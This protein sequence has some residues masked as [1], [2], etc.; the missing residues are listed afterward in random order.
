MRMLTSLSVDEILLPRYVKWNTNFRNWLSNVENTPSCLKY[1]NIFYLCSRQSW[2]ADCSGF[3]AE[4]RFEELYLRKI[5]F[6]IKDFRTI[7]F[8]F[9]VISKTFRPICS[10]AFFRCLSKSGTYTE[11]RTTSF[12]E[13][14]RV[15][16][17]DSVS[18]NRVQ[19]LSILVLLLT[20]SQ[21]WTCNLLMIVSLE[22]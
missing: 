15:A 12:I 17:S 4:I 19:L 6:I 13:S 5:I 18:H 9:I 2:L 8:I 7:V 20:C 3:A 22:A 16:C 10:P 11:H 1:M 21:D 14:T